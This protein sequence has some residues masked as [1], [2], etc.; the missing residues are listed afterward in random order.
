LGT[1]FFLSL[2]ILFGS[3]PPSV[4]AAAASQDPIVAGNPSGELDQIKTYTPEQLLRASLATLGDD[5]ARQL[6]LSAIDQLAGQA[7]VHKPAAPPQTGVAALLHH[8]EILFTQIPPRLEAVLRGAAQLPAE[9][10]RVF[11]PLTQ[12]MGAGRIAL[13]LGGMI[14]VLLASHGIEL[15][16]RRTT[17][18]FGG[19][20]TIPLMGSMAKFGGSHSG[21]SARPI[22]DHG[23]YGRRCDPVFS[24]F[25]FR[26]TGPPPL[27]PHPRS[28]CPG[29]SG[30][31]ADR[32]SL[33]ATA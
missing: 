3:G 24:L 14:I 26:G 15:L 33:R 12:S 13:L 19:R 16:L 27:W 6:L 8:F 31:A 28:D 18:R 32:D 21:R 30:H 5:N 17:L 22:G 20:L 29:T 1:L 23:L 4:H 9:M 7:S 10:G 11:H 2:S 25:R